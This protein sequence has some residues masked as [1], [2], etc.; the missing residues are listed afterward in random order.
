MFAWALALSVAPQWHQR[1]HSDANR[2]EHSCAVTFVAAGSYEHHA[3]P[4][5]AVE[6]LLPVALERIAFPNPSW[7]SSPFLSTSVL[8]HAPP[9]HS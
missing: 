1:I 8:E 9:A 3:Q 7:V 6:P 4:P 5:L 2:V